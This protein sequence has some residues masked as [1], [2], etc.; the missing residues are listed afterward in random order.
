[1][2]NASSLGAGGAVVAQ[3]DQDLDAEWA[4]SN[5]D[6]RH[7]FTR[8][9]HRRAAV[10]R[11]PEVARERRRAGRD[12]RRVVDEHDV[13]GASGL[14]VH[15][16]RRRRDEQRRER[17]ERLAAGRLHRRDR[18]RWPIRRCCAFF[19]TAAFRC[20]RSALF[21]TSPRNII[22][23]PGGHVVNAHV[24]AR[25]APRRQPRGDALRSTPT[26]CS[27]R[28]SGR[29]STRTSTRSTFGQVTRFAPHADD[30]AQPEVQVLTCAAHCSPSRRPRVRPDVR[31]AW[32]ADAAGAA[33]RR[34]SGRRRRSA[35]ASTSSSWTSI[36]RD[37]NGAAAQGLKRRLRDPRGR[38]VAGDP[39]VRLRGDHRQ[40]AA[41]QSATTLST[42]GADKG[43]VPVT[44]AAPQP[45]A[46][47]GH[48]A[49]P[50]PATSRPPWTPRTAR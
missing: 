44:V 29:R 49:A 48:A 47:A 50:T 9:L 4:L 40:R 39:D 16:A 35:A 38:Q 45:A 46:A 6:R 26:T 32:P 43:A 25:H 28:F 36:V 30:H 13:H 37:K 5:F 27:T 8:E 15:G 11:R 34:R 19:N 42:A 41:V 7:Q 2:D 23:G 1:M 18:S 12:R 3:N 31:G 10:R 24:H 22:I 14:A 33:S 17:H 20:R 21:G